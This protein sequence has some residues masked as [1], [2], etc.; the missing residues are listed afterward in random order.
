MAT[1]IFCDHC[2]LKIPSATKFF[3]GKCPTNQPMAQQAIVQAAYQ[4]QQYSISQNIYQGSTGGLLG[5]SGGSGGYTVTTQPAYVP[6]PV[7]A[8]SERYYA[9]VEVDL[10]EVCVPIW[11]ERANNLCKA[12]KD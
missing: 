1:R 6:S 3:F 2:G 5:G 4:A 8:K 7:P 11:Y 12:N 9:T 10:C